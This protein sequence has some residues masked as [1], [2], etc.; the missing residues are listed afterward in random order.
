[1]RPRPDGSTSADEWSPYTASYGRVQFYG[2]RYDQGGRRMFPYSEED[3]TPDVADKRPDIW[4]KWLS[5]V[6]KREGLDPTLFPLGDRSSETA[7]ETGRVAVDETGRVWRMGAKGPETFEKGAWGAMKP[8]PSP[9]VV[10]WLEAFARIDARPAQWKK[11]REQRAAP[12]PVN[13]TV[14][15]KTK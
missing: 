5:Q 11:W 14:T 1:M 6:K 13:P 4:P 15:P 7:P 10:A 8:G 9:D 3:G 12:I 2:C